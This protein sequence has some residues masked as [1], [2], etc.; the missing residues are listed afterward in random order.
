M[1]PWI[2]LETQVKSME[3]FSLY[4]AKPISSSLFHACTN[5][6]YSTFKV[7]WNYCIYAFF[8]EGNKPLD[9]M[10]QVL[11]LFSALVDTA[12]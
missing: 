4:L 8:P 9:I 11:F 1:N 12:I 5:F 2:L 10:N 7:Y 6:Y 3:I